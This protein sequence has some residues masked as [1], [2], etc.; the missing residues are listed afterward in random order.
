[1]NK[2]ETLFIVK[3]DQ[4]EEQI[5][6]VLDRLIKQIESTQGKVAIIEHWGNRKLAYPVRYRGERLWGGYYILLTYLGGGATVD[7]VERNIKILDPTFRY[8]SVKLEDKVD[9]ASVTEMVVTRKKEHAVPDR[10]DWERDEGRGRPHMSEPPPEAAAKP[11]SEG[12]GFEGGSRE[13]IPEPVPEDRDA[14]IGDR[15]EE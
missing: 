4:T 14:A 12:A 5:Q 3:P 9:P 1:M 13:D 2:Y 11:E 6:A 7:E 15:D 10:R 8:M